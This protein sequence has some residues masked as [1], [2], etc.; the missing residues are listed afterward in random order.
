M[1]K[2]SLLILLV[3]ITIKV[4]AQDNYEIQVY[5]S[6][7][8]NK[9]MTMFELHSNYTINGEKEMLKGVLPSNHALHETIEITHGVTEN[10]ELGFISLPIIRVLM[11]SK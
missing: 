3:I 2:N 5:G 4:T 8:M 10:F 11:D 9:G 7:T 1:K 6:Q